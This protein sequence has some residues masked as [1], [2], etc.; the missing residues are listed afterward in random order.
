MSS[1]KNAMRVAVI[2]VSIYTLYRR[3]FHFKQGKMAGITDQS[4]LYLPNGN[5]PIKMLYESKWFG[6]CGHVVNNFYKIFYNWIFQA[7]AS[8]L[9]SFFSTNGNRT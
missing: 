7:G 5:E 1:A 4:A 8:I 6:F 2:G 3:L 9:G